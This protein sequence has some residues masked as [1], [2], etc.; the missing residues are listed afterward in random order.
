MT[1]RKLIFAIIA[2]TTICVLLMSC[3]TLKK[4]NDEKDYGLLYGTWV[5]ENNN[6]VRFIFGKMVRNPDGT[7]AGYNN[8]FD[9]KPLLIGKAI[10]TNKWI[11]SEGNVW[12][13][14][15]FYI[16]TYFEGKKISYYYLTRVSN[17]GRIIE[18]ISNPGSVGEYPT[19][20]DP[21]NRW[22]QI[23]YRQ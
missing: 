23:L 6:D 1:T 14:E 11:D 9:P 5:N 20:I 18:F 8:D 4:E 16:G 12:F 21:A 19:E 22:Y 15:E 17:S 13:Q 7:F 3:A 2:T 10:I